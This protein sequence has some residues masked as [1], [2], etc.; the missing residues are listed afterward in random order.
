MTHKYGKVILCH[1]AAAKRVKQLYNNFI[2]L[3]TD[4]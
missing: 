3:N 4:S 1:I 2:F